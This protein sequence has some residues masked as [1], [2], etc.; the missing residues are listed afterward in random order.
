[1]CAR[2][3]GARGALRVHSARDREARC[4]AEARGS[5]KTLSNAMWCCESRA[6]KGRTAPPPRR[7]PPRP[8]AAP[9][10]PVARAPAGPPPPPPLPP[11]E[12]QTRILDFSAAILNDAALIRAAVAGGDGAPDAASLASSAAAADAAAAS[13]RALGCRCT[14]IARGRPE[15]AHARLRFASVTA[16][17]LFL[18][19]DELAC[20]DGNVRAARRALI[21][22]LK[23]VE[24]EVDA[25]TAALAA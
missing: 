13:L 7:A 11:L 5:S 25:V 12:L 8:A 16:E 14:L 10:P 3:D 19:L 4:G 1:M 9:A 20:V 17:S 2:A 15:D 23:A 6:P 18:L 21:E 22:R 24:K